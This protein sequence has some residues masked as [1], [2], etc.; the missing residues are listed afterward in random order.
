VITLS[1]YWMARHTRFKSEWT[2]EVQRNGAEIVR[3][4]NLLL[5]AAGLDRRVTSGWR[6]AILN[7]ATKG[8]AKKSTHM[9]AQGVDLEDVDRKLSKW[10]MAHLDVLAEIGLWIEHPDYT[11]TWLHAQSVPPKS[12]RRVYIPA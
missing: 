1:E 12:G 7:A 2:P 8:A 10:A 3:R 5:R 11:L 4:A 6:P 9:L